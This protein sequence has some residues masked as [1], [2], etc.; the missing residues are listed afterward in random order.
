MII[1]AFILL[2]K[3]VPHSDAMLAEHRLKNQIIVG[4]APGP[5]G[6]SSAAGLAQEIA[7]RER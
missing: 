6:H 5:S 3:V 2:Q 7:E 4:T 1:F